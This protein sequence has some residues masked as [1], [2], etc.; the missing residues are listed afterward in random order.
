MYAGLSSLFGL[1]IALETR[2]LLPLTLLSLGMAVGFL[3]VQARRGRG[4]GPLLLGSAAALVVAF[5]K[6]AVE[7]SALTI[8][9]LAALLVA[10]FW[11]RG[12]ARRRVP[13]ASGAMS[14]AARVT[15]ALKTAQ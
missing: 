10:A 2:F 7:S 12:L 1:S 9:G 13:A 3:A 14:S 15:S 6:F 8:T 4:F 11:S 5:G